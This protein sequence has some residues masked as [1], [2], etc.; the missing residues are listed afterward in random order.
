MGKIRGRY[1]A[2]VMI[3]FAVDENDPQ[4]VDYEQIRERVCSGLTPELEDLLRD[5]LS[6][7][8]TRV[9]VYQMFANVWHD[10]R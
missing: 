8:H 3:E 4:L 5:E 7:Q 10:L 2:K 6:D 1:V 9:R